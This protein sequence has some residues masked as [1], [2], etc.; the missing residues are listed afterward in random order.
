M[1]KL[2]PC[3]NSLEILGKDGLVT[4][5]VEYLA[6]PTILKPNNPPTNRLKYSIGV[7]AREKSANCPM[8][9][10]KK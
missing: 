2:T 10:L 6:T 8:T 5:I 9:V 1:H 4:L 3:M 7:E